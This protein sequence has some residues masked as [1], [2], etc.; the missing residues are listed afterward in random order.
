MKKFIVPILI[1]GFALPVYGAVK[2][3]A[4]TPT[5]FV[6]DDSNAWFGVSSSTPM[7]NFSMNVTLAS[8]S[9]THQYIFV[10]SSTTVTNAPPSTILRAIDASGR[11]YASSTRPTLSLCGTNP[12]I[13]GTDSMGKITVGTGNASGCRAT[14]TQ[15]WGNAPYCVV[16][17]NGTTA[18]SQKP[19]IA[20]SATTTS[21][22]LNIMGISTTTGAIG[23]T[24]IISNLVVHY[25]C[26]GDIE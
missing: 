19:Y 3:F 24:P 17:S 22:T 11:V 9:T 23:T 15:S 8:S 13:V 18:S 1:L 20:T 4:G 26:Q 6:Y 21:T 2:S 10:L 16:V 25:Y 7:A 12:T 14:F 5:P